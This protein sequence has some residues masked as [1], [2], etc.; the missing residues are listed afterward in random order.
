MLSVEGFV[1]AS[2]LAKKVVF[3][4]K[5]ASQQLSL[6]D[7]YDFGMRA[8]KST[9]KILANL[10]EEEPEMDDDRLLLRSLRDILGPKVVNNDKTVLQNILKDLFPGL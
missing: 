7:H 2:A 3:V 10:R 5:V 1:E 4:F 9:T 8:I 6:Q